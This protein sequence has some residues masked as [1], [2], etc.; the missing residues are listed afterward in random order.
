MPCFLIIGGLNGHSEALRS[1]PGIVRDLTPDGLLFAGGIFPEDATE[2]VRF[3]CEC[4]YYT[5]QGAVFMDRFF[6]TL[7]SLGIFSAVI[8][9]VFDAPLDEFLTR[10]MAAERR[11]P[12][13]HIVHV[14]PAQ[15]G[16]VAIFG[17]G[18]C[19]SDQT[20]TNTGYYSRSLAQYYLRPLLTCKLPR[21]ILLVSDPPES[22]Q[23]EL[24]DQRLADALIAAYHPEVCVAGR[25]SVKNPIERIGETLLV[26]PGD[27]SAGSAAWLDLD[28]PMDDRAKLLHF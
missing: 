3:V 12:E 13:L 17:L 20:S 2:V 27:F 24:G 16:D 9:G 11:H 10:G 7:G 21:K 6:A 18:G 28:L 8:P 22:W 19:I 25:R 26:H 5:E 15:K 4:E 23:G 14:T 1:L